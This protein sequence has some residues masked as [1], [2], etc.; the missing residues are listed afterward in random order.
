MRPRIGLARIWQE[1]NS[2]SQR[3][4][5][6]GDFQSDWLAGEALLAGLAGRRDELAGF[7][8]GLGDAEPVPLVTACAWPGGPAEP[9]LMAAILDRLERAVNAA[10]TLDGVLVSLHGAMA[11]P[12]EPDMEGAVLRLLRNMLGP[13]VPIVATLD[14]HAN[15]T[16][17]MVEAADAIT[18]YRQCPHL[19]MRE[20]GRR[21]AGLL[22]ELLAGR[23]R[24]EM[25]FVKL[26]LVTPCER[27]AT[28]EGPMAGWF[29]LARRLERMPGIRDISLFPVQPWLDVPEFGWSVLVV[30]DAGHGAAARKLA[31]R[32]AN[33]AWRHRRDFTV[34]KWEPAAAVAHAAAAARGPVVLADGADATNGGS[35]GDSTQLLREMLAQDIAVPACLTLVDPGAVAAAW[36]AGEGA[37]LAL[38]LG[39][40]VS[41][42]FHRPVSVHASVRRLGHGRF[43]VSGH[44]GADVDMGRMAVLA[45]GPIRVVASERAGPGH[46]PAV[47]RHMGVEPAAAQIVV[48][49]STVGHLRSYAPFMAENLPVECAGPSP[50]RLDR[51][52]Y[53]RP[54]RPFYPLDPTMEWTAR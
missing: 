26:P 30:G 20:T 34:D 25:A 39:A 18:A 31:A 29:A 23:P 27:F 33:H 5:G 15:L 41:T 12:A 37:R 38:D 52:P 3:P 10:G 48:V 22:L 49:K 13:G 24:P 40:G 17:R 32:L 8:D 54:Q 44:L 43:S 21:G 42:R 45:I 36:R 28:D 16:R 9:A 50:S 51:L 7:A 19:D 35:P 53:R 47:F 14:H 4:S 11:G 46:D 2:F 6:I 1:T